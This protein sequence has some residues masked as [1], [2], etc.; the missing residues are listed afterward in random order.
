MKYPALYEGTW[1][2]EQLEV[3]RTQADIARE[4]G[5]H[6]NNVRY[7]IL[8]LGLQQFL[9][10]GRGR[11][12]KY[13]LLNDPAWL[14]EQYVTRKRTAN[15]IADEI[16]SHPV[17]VRQR[18]HKYGIRREDSNQMRICLTVK[19]WGD[20]A[21]G[22]A[23]SSE[24]KESSKAEE[25]ASLIKGEGVHVRLCIDVEDENEAGIIAGWN[26]ICVGRERQH[27]RR[28]GR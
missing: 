25:I 15:D 5:C 14:R 4:A 26:T 6:T 27:A 13:P 24:P 20:I 28:E 7:A 1:L 16:G 8:V 18:M 23:Y 9:Q 22:M 3:G 10:H 2:R 19:E 21:L 17:H 12:Q 11:P